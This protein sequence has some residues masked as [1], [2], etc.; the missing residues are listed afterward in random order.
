MVHLA[1]EM[2]KGE[3]DWLR[4][5]DWVWTD[6][7]VVL[8]TNEESMVFLRIERLTR[9]CYLLSLITLESVPELI[10]ALHLQSKVNFCF[11]LYLEN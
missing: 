2:V 6:P 3:R 7:Q 4:V 8:G 5:G 10:R 11:K 9:T 1:V